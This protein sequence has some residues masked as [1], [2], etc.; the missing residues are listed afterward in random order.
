MSV[1]T[2]QGE[3]IHVWELKAHI[4]GC[5]SWESFY[6]CRCGAKRSV[7][8]ERSGDAND[9]SSVFWMTDSD[10]ER[11]QD[12]LSGAQPKSWDEISCA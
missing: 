3:H 4:D 1:L 2:A 6:T 10:C 5:H 11:C 7:G 9:F 12:L 8:G